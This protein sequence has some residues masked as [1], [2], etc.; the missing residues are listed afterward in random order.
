[1]VDFKYHVV[2]IVAVFLALAVGIVL[3]TNVLSGDVLKN[4]KTQTSQL[5]KEAQDLRTQVDT[6]QAQLGADQAFAQALEPMA[7]AGRLSGASIVVVMLPDA[8]KD[9]RDAAVKTLVAAGATITGEVDVTSNFTDPQQVSTLDSLATSLGA[10]AADTNVDQDTQTRAGALLAAALVNR[11]GILAPVVAVSGPPVAIVSVPASSISPTGSASKSGSKSVHRPATKPAS[12]AINGTNAPSSG[13]PTP[14]T[15]PTPTLNPPPASPTAFLDAAS[16]EVLAGLAK[17][18]FIK[19]AQPP[20]AHA[21]LALVVAPQVPSKPDTDTASAAKALVDL[22][23]SFPDAGGRTVVAG[24]AGSAASGG[25]LS[26]LR[27][28]APVSKTVTG[29]DDADTAIG[30]IALVFAL[31]AGALGAVGQYGT[32]PGAQGPLPTPTPS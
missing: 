20:T 29:V 6:Q 22:V 32:G 12:P 9:V 31:Q 23:R 11:V 26:A 16:T 2:S 18:G 17:A 27:G 21:T 1:V 5:R 25:F 24:P 4:L 28:S 7:V 8:P 19:V 14:S 10:P 13:T 15:L 30:R 3:G